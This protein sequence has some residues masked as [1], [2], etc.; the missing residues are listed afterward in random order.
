MRN[1]SVRRAMIALSV[2][3]AMAGGITT[4]VQL[5]CAGPVFSRNVVLGLAGGA[6]SMTVTD[7]QPPIEWSFDVA[8]NLGFKVAPLVER[9]GLLGMNLTTVALPLWIP[10]LI[11]TGIAVATDVRRRRVASLVCPSC[12][13]SLRANESGTCPECGNPVVP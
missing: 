11:T 7:V 3:L 6:A 10:L 4:L 12:N 8:M 9:S 5:V 2:T 13:Y 1:V